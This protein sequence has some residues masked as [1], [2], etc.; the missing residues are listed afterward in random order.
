M[1]RLPPLMEVVR[2]D[3]IS[4]QGAIPS[5]RFPPATRRRSGGKLPSLLRRPF[6]RRR[7]RPA[8]SGARARAR[9]D[10]C[11]RAPTARSR[12]TRESV[13]R[14]RCTL[15]GF[16]CSCGNCR[17]AIQ[18]LRSIGTENSTACSRPS[19]GTSRLAT[20]RPFTTTSTSRSPA[21][22]ERIERLRFALDDGV[23]DMTPARRR[24]SRRRR[25]ARAAF[26]VKTPPSPSP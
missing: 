20:T 9:A 7:A 22:V 4:L 11:R 18:L 19:A 12:A 5:A 24:E 21:L 2:R 23:A 3:D 6:P 16:V 10:R 8:Q 14:P 25:P 26:P 1:R 13:F 17:S 15:T